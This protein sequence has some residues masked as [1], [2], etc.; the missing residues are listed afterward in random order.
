MCR[1]NQGKIAVTIH[2]DQSVERQLNILSKP[3]SMEAIACNPSLPPATPAFGSK[4]YFNRYERISHISGFFTTLELI[5][6]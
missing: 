4:Q 2:L 3:V 1:R 5:H 6:D